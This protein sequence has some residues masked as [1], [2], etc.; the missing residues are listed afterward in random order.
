MRIFILEQQASIQIDENIFN[1]LSEWMPFLNDLMQPITDKKKQL[2]V[3]AS[4]L[5]DTVDQ[6]I[7]LQKYF[8]AGQLILGA[9]LTT[10]E[11]TY[12]INN[13]GSELNILPAEELLTSDEMKH[14]LE[15][16][17][18]D[19]SIAGELS[20]QPIIVVEDATQELLKI[21]EKFSQVILNKDLYTNL[22][23]ILLSS[24]TLLRATI[25]LE[26]FTQ[27]SNDT[28]IKLKI[29]STEQNV[30]IYFNG[31]EDQFALL[32]KWLDAKELSLPQ[33]EDNAW[34]VDSPE[35]FL[36]WYNNLRLRLENE[37]SYQTLMNY[38]SMFDTD[39][40]KYKQNIANEIKKIC[41]AA[42]LNDHEKR[43]QVVQFCNSIL[44]KRQDVEQKVY[45]DL[46]MEQLVGHFN[47]D[48]NHYLLNIYE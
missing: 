36:D 27:K 7:E 33:A 3:N 28:Y 45:Q 18:F 37:C 42:N 1:A 19:Q 14:F 16:G 12:K 13:K 31:S 47:A 11:R 29:E 34:L 44:N 20:I 24:N 35:R 4:F 38:V 26:T 23:S 25:K 32:D 2:A 21:G 43:K 5:I 8:M 30:L 39:V 48:K 15:S 6:Y 41:E 9:I 10:V 46:N 22:K 17:Q 40:E